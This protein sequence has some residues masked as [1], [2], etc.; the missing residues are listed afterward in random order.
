MFLSGVSRDQIRVS[1][2]RDVPVGGPKTRTGW[3]SASP[4]Q[5]NMHSLHG[6]SK[7]T[8]SPEGDGETEHLTE[9]PSNGKLSNTSSER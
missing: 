4:D 5:I 3:F 7:L 6:E 8:T 2:Y 1:I 9:S